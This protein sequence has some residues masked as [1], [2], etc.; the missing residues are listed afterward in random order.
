MWQGSA[1][2]QPTGTTWPSLACSITMKRS[3]SSELACT[4]T[5]P[6]SHRQPGLGHHGQQ[7]FHRPVVSGQLLAQQS[8]QSS[9]E[10]LPSY[11]TH[12][13]L[14]IPFDP[15]N[16]LLPPGKMVPFAGWSMPIQYKDSIMESTTW[17]REHASL[18]DVA[19]MC[20]L[21]LTV[22]AQQQA[23]T[24]GPLRATG[25]VHAA[26]DWQHCASCWRVG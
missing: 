6:P 8:N 17:C 1:H 24:G 5:V 13:P 12:V 16:L 21:S 2:L 26:H 3:R 4:Q 15:P 10:A 19:H 7:C 9:S 14:V 20:G 11:H 18:F 22:S 25:H 23:V